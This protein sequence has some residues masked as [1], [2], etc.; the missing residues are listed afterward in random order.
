MAIQDI[1][2]TSPEYKTALK[3]RGVDDVTK[4]VGTPLTVGY[5]GGKDGLLD[6]QQRILKI[7]HY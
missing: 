2:Q 1:I 6:Q 5:F 4:V 7:E 3:K